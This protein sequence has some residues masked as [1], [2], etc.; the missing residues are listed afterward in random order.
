[1][2]RWL[3]IAVL[4]GFLLVPA[5]VYTW[6]SSAKTGAGKIWLT[7]R[8]TS[9]VHVDL[10]RP[11]RGPGD[12]E[13]IRQ[14]L[15]NKRIRAKAIGHS[16]LVC[17]FTT[18]WIRS[19][20]ATYFLPRGRLVAGGSIRYQDIYELALLGGTR[21]YDDARGTLVVIRTTQKPR[22]H[23]LRFDLIG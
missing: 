21:L 13:F 4:T 22:R 8:E 3:T 14:L 7:S 12:M 1:M 9:R 6:T 15:F 11:G 5:L 17:T 10:G 2:S 18:R 16:E 20:T 19:C 23:R